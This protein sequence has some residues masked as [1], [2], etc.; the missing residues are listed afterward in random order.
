MPY[1]CVFQ[2]RE[3]R[4]HPGS[5]REIRLA[6]C[7]ITDAKNRVLLLHR[8]TATLKQWEIPGGKLEHTETA[9][10]A[11]TRE[12]YEEMGVEVLVHK[13]LGT[14]SF[15]QDGCRM[16]YTWFL[17]RILAGDPQVIELD[18]HDMAEYHAIED[19]MHRH[20]LS[21]NT[22]NF[23]EELKGGRFTLQSQ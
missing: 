19:L 14:R 17:A 11:A 8:N 3:S 5:M 4:Y 21:P 1:Q 7:V 15:V 12:L 16:V 23:L 9:E 22:R 6:G 18:T 2:L 10:A 20:D 13:E